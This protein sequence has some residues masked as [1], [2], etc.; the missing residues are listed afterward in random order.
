MDIDPKTYPSRMFV[1]FT[2]H[3]QL[4]ADASGQ[5]IT[6]SVQRLGGDNYV[7]QAIP[8]G[9]SPSLATDSGSF[10]CGFRMGL[11]V[12][13][14]SAE[15]TTQGGK[16][17]SQDSKPSGEPSGLMGGDKSPKCGIDEVLFEEIVQ[18]LFNPNRYPELY[19]SSGTQ[20]AATEV[21]ARV[22]VEIVT[23]YRTIKQKQDCPIVQRLNSLL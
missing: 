10:A 9:E 18:T 17:E 8:D 6:V 3:N 7:Q 15:N 20:K 1:R 21:E 5:T 16:D 13:P 2:A 11:S 12:N 23:A 19:H 22:A 14:T 4:T